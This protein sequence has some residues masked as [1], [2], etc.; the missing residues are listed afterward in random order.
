MPCGKIHIGKR[1]GR[2]K[3]K[4]GKK[5]YCKPK[6]RKAGS[7]RPGGALKAKVVSVRRRKAGSS[8]PAGSSMPAGS[9]KRKRKRKGGGWK[10]A[11]GIGAAALGTAG[12]A[13]GAYK[14]AKDM[15]HGL[16]AVLTGGKVRK[17]RFK[18]TRKN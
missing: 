15:R 17:G 1:G 11:L 6:G 14:G 12:L 9:L 4:K 10:K 13:Y 5:C 18:K 2:Y 8:K 3:I 16:E 7:S